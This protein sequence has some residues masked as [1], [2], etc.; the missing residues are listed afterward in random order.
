MLVLLI[1]L[2]PILLVLSIFFA[3]HSVKKYKKK[4]KEREDALRRMGNREY[5]RLQSEMRERAERIQNRLNR[6]NRLNVGVNE[7]D[8]NQR[9][10]SGVDQWRAG[11][12]LPPIYGPNGIKIQ[13]REDEHWDTKKTKQPEKIEFLTEDDMEL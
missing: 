10:R 8:L 7:E 13:M 5:N 6:I 2:F 4:K 12:N 1:R 11:R 3:R 9:I